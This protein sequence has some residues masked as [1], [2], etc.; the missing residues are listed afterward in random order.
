MKPDKYKKKDYIKSRHYKSCGDTLRVKQQNPM[1]IIQ[2]EDKLDNLASKSPTERASGGLSLSKALVRFL[3]S[4]IG[5]RWDDVYSE[6]SP[7]LGHLKDDLKWYVDLDAYKREDGTI[8]AIRHWGEQEVRGFYVMNGILGEQRKS[9]KWKPDTSKVK[10]TYVD[11]FVVFKHNNIYFKAPL[12]KSIPAKEL[13]PGVSSADYNRTEYHI[14]YTDRRKNKSYRG[15]KF[16]IPAT[17]I[18]QLS[19]KEIMHWD[20]PNTEINQNLG[21]FYW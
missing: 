16:A 1:E 8:V 19:S 12:D 3:R 15:P 7:K 21:L 2:D 13:I 5:K 4:N 18:R 11:G 10:V 6:L 14:I 9:L 17:H 20:L